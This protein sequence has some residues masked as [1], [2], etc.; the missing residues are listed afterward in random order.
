MSPRQPWFKQY[1]SDWRGDTNLR[2][3]S[4]AARG[5]WAE[6]LGMMHEADPRGYLIVAGLPV[7]VDQLALHVGRPLKEVRTAME[8]LLRHGVPS[9]DESGIVYSRRMV[10]DTAKVEKAIADGARGGNPTLKGR[11]KGPVNGVVGH[12]ANG[13]HI[14]ARDA[15][16]LASGISDVGITDE[17]RGEPERGPGRR[18]T[19]MPPPPKNAAFAGKFIVPDFL[20]AEFERKSGKPYEARQAWYRRLD[21][22]WRNRSIGEDDLK[23]LRA[24]FAEWVGVTPA[25][26]AAPRREPA[27]A[28]WRDRCKHKPSCATPLQCQRLLDAEIPNTEVPA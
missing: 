15:R 13:T 3:C 2:A 21:E 23:F 10:R 22:E 6:C 20:D 5:L 16:D 9:V 7:T 25:T 26:T 4:L 27:Y 12:S 8:E 1:P 28:T 11:V 24:R 14:H 19:L 18:A 17:P